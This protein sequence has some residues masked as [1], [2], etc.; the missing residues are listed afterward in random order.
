[1][2]QTV[3]FQDSAEAKSHIPFHFSWCPDLDHVFPSAFRYTAEELAR[4]DVD[5]ARLVAERKSSALEVCGTVFPDHHK[6][7]GT[8][9]SYGVC[10]A[11]R[12]KSGQ[13]WLVLA[14][15]TGPATYAAARL[16]SRLPLDQRLL[17]SQQS[18]PVH[19]AAVRATLQRDRDRAFG[20]ALSVEKEEIL[21]GPNQCDPSSS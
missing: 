8:L 19:W 4:H 2:F 7:R 13:I 16:A 11:Q 20:T 10:V 12:R 3:P 1:M 5:A 15:V 21:V 17:H 9:E 14:G 6:Q 18:S